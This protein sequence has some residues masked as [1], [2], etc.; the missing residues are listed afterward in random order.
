MHAVTAVLVLGFTLLA[1]PRPV[2]L[3]PAVPARADAV[4]VASAIVENATAHEVAT[5][6]GQEHL[7]APPAPAVSHHAPSGADDERAGRRFPWV[8]LQLSG[9]LTIPPCLLYTSPSPRDAH[10]S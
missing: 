5:T 3:R 8:L 10:E 7:P 1:P 9:L 6:P 2:L 4:G